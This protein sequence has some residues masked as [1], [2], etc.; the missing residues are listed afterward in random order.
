MHTVPLEN[1]TSLFVLTW[2]I[3]LVQQNLKINLHLK[4]NE[5]SVALVTQKVDLKKEPD[6][7]K[8]LMNPIIDL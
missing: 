2:P 8:K 3:F 7:K 6:F 5:N 1:L 4:K